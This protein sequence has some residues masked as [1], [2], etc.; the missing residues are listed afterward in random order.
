[1]YLNLG[2]VGNMLDPWR[3]E[4]TTWFF[5]ILSI[6]KESSSLTSFYNWRE[7]CKRW[8]KRFFILNKTCW[9]HVSSLQLRTSLPS[10]APWPYGLMHLMYWTRRSWVQIP[11]GTWIITFTFVAICGNYRYLLLMRRG[12]RA[13]IIEMAI[14]MWIGSYGIQIQPRVALSIDMYSKEEFLMYKKQ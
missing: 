11:H 6:F 1:M 5:S 4:E 12:S 3:V 13:S 8:K 14:V 9:K 10:K 7:Q 2:N